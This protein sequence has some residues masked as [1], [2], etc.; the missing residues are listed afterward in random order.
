MNFMYANLFKDLHKEERN[1]NAPFFETA[2][3]EIEVSS[4]SNAVD[5]WQIFL[6][7]QL[8]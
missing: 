2:R 3:R 5:N 4:V 8:F 6:L 1:K 7:P